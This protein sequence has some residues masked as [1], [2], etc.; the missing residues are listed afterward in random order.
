MI[1]SQRAFGPRFLALA[2]LAAVVLSAC[3]GL[4]FGS[5]STPEPTV[6]PLPGTVL[7]PPR[8]LL[9]FTLTSHTGDPIRLSDLRG[10]AAVIFFGYTACPDVCPV[11]VADFKRIK[12]ELGEDAPR[13]SLSSSPSIRPTRRAFGDLPR[14]LRPGVHRHD[15]R[16][17]T[18]R[19]IAQDYGVFF[20][21]HSYDESGNYLV[22][23][24]ASTFVVGP[25]GRL[26]I[27]YPYD[28]EPWIIADGV[29]K[30]LPN[31][32]A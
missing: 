21:R 13:S 24:T 7:E 4:S 5:D 32:D 9:D 27:I 29:R 31:R 30:L 6:T 10:K 28:T 26:H 14:Q 25:D 22:N 2:V 17:A 3:G 19:D 20:Q 12:A 15:R 1:R 16:Q 18:L 23:H 11:T 8:D